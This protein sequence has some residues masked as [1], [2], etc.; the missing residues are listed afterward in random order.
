MSLFR[1]EVLEA[2][3]R[4]L[5]GDV[6]LVQPLSL[7]L[8]ALMFIVVGAALLTF[9]GTREYTRKET[10]RG[11]IVPETGTTA[12]RAMRGG[13]LVDL[14]VVEGQ[15]VDLGTPLFESQVDVETREGRVSERRLDSLQERMFQ[16]DLRE[17][18]M[19]NRFQGEE[20]RLKSLVQGLQAEVVTMSRRHDLQVEVVRVADDRLKKFGNLLREE[21][22]SQVEYDAIQRQSLEAKIT[23]ESLEQQKIASTNSLRNEEFQL[24]SLP[25]QKREESIR[26]AAERAQ[27]NEARAS[28]DAETTYIVRAPVKGKITSVGGRLGEQLDPSRPVVTIVP[29]DTPLE[30]I[31]LVPSSA[32]GFI[33]P[34]NEVNLLLDAF[35]YQ[36]FGSVSATVKEISA[37]PFLPG[38]LISPI[39]YPEPVYRVKASLSREVILA[40]GEDVPLKPGMTLV[41]D[42]VLDRRSILEWMFEPLL[43]ATKRS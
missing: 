2:Q 5:H 34:G 23:L 32:S 27:L 15:I 19:K 16:I 12:V 14:L 25:T 35:P 43:A 24:R 30:A 29:V 38:E 21:V 37:T 13:E 31:I 18:E 28:V 1:P 7:K 3:R 10:A 42:I 33:E 26:L 41:G 40:Y 11:F 4:K 8:I 39:N 17:T 6:I 36:K 9:A 22:I 20:L